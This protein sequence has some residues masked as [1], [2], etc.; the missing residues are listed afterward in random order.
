MNYTIDQIIQLVLDQDTP[1]LRKQVELYELGRKS[2]IPPGWMK[3]IPK[4]TEAEL[5]MEKHP[6]QF[7]YCECGCKCHS[8]S[9]KGLEYSIYNDL[10][11]KL[12]FTLTRGHGWRGPQVGPRYANF[13][14]AVMA[15]QADWDKIP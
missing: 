4:P 7:E 3:F 8:G 9:S 2:V 12:A 6:L 14:E 13:S 1:S 15:A 5:R 11:N 10:K